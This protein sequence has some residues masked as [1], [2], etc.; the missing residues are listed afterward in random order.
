LHYIPEHLRADIVENCQKHTNKDGV[1]ALSVI[2]KKPFV[3]L[4]HGNEPSIHNWYS[5]ELLSYYRDWE[6][7][8]VEEKIIDCDSS[9][10]PHEHVISKVIATK[11]VPT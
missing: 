5:G 10:I 8:D 11:R 9:D 3:Q 6:V 2:V 7:M 4:P 1:H